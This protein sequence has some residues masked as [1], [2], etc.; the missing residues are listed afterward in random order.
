MIERAKKRGAGGLVFL[1]SPPPGGRPRLAADH[2]PTKNTLH[3]D[4]TGGDL[5]LFTETPS[6]AS[7][8]S[9]SAGAR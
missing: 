6:V 7:V 2:G 3:K 1:A 9:A 4:R 5:F 8:R